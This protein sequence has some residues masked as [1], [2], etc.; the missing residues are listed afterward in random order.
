M[1]GTARIGVL[2]LYCE[3]LAG[4]LPAWYQGWVNSWLVPPPPPEL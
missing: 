2:P 3:M 4:T 1:S